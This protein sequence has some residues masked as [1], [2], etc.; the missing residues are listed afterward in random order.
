MYP[1]LQQIAYGLGK[2]DFDLHVSP[3]QDAHGRLVIAHAISGRRLMLVPPVLPR[4]DDWTGI[5]CAALNDWVREHGKDRALAMLR[6]LAEPMPLPRHQGRVR[7]YLAK[8]WAR[9]FPTR[10][11]GR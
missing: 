2:H 5:A 8:L 4:P 6:A 9:L 10:A 11:A 7:A 1:R 3:S